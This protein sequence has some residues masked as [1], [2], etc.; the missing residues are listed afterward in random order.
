[1]QKTCFTKRLKDT[2]RLKTL[3]Y[4]NKLEKGVSKRKAATLQRGRTY[5]AASQA[6]QKGINTVMPT[7][8]AKRQKPPE[9]QIL[10]V[11]LHK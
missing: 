11:S 8:E 2:C 5:R 7:D 6:K 4:L 3:K 9:V 10:N 1:M